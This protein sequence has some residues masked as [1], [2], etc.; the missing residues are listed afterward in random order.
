MV[1]IHEQEKLFKCSECE[2]ASVENKHVQLH[3]A[4]KHKQ[5]KPFKCN[6]CNY[7]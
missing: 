6:E 2:Y 5:E 7:E 4:F 1:L 3:V